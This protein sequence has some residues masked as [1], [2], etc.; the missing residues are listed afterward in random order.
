MTKPTS[1]WRDLMKVHPAAEMFPL[2]SADELKVLGEDIKENGLKLPIELFND[3]R[4]NISVLDGR[5]RLDAMELVGY[6]FSKGTNGSLHATDP[7][8]KSIY[9][10]WHYRNAKPDAFVISANIHRRHLT[11]EQRR[12]LA[13]KLLTA[14]PNCSNRSIA[15]QVKLDKN[16]VQ[17]VRADLETGGE[18]HHVEER[19]GRDGKAQPAER[20]SSRKQRT[21]RE[22]PVVEA[23]DQP[24]AHVEPPV[25]VA[26]PANV[27]VEDAIVEPQD[28]PPHT[29]HCLRDLPFDAAL[30]AVKDWFAALPISQQS[31]VLA[32]LESANDTVDVG[33]AMG[34]V[35]AA[36][37]QAEKAA[38]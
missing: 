31:Q 11:I 22:Q 23:S 17:S 35:E 37:R 2:M 38:A 5:N 25:V 9:M 29:S 13:A 32:A 8:G 12:E 34:D 24:A 28:Q 26:E 6:H 3:N 33:A 20:K 27:N 15:E 10:D 19:V 16:T 7:G 21:T 14:D 36:A 4:N 1:N 30:A 18:I